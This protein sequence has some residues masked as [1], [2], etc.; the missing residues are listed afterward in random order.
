GIGSVSIVAG[1]QQAPTYGFDFE[2]RLDDAAG[3]LLGTGGINPP[4]EKL[5]PGAVGFGTANFSLEA[6]TDGKF[7][8]LYLVSKPKDAKEGTQIFLQAIQFNPK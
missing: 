4:K 2:I 6:V 5:K 7:H 1:W 3:K 8:T